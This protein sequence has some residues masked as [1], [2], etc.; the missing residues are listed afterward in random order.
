MDIQLKNLINVLPCKGIILKRNDIS[1]EW[2]AR[3]SDFEECRD[4]YVNAL[5]ADDDNQVIEIQKEPVE[6]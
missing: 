3:V 6:R 5:Y 2:Q 1:E 4:M